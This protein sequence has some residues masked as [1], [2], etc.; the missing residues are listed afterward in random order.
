RHDKDGAGADRQ[1]RVTSVRERRGTVQRE[2]RVSKSERTIALRSQIQQ[3]R[4]QLAYFARNRCTS[5]R[6]ELQEDA[7][8]MTRRRMPEF[9][10][11]V[12]TPADEVVGEVEA[13][14]TKHLADMAT[15]LGLT[16]PE[17]PPTPAPPVLAS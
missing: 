15:E 1:A 5:V 7:S 6:S 14:A 16:P 8:S 10:S 17:V 9:E 12:R 13:G 2:R 11:Y 4:V 3:A